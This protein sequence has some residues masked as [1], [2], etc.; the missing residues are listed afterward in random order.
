MLI[1][2]VS[3]EDRRFKLE[4]GAGSD[5]VH[6]NPVYSFAVTRLTLD[7]GVT[8]TGLVLTM[9]RG[10]ELVCSA[11]DLLGLQL[12]GKEIEELMSNFGRTFRQLADDAQLR[13]LGPHKGVVHLALASITNACFDAWAK[14]RQLPLWKLL[15]SLSPT[16]ILALLD[17]SYLEEVLD[18]PSAEKILTTHLPSR[19]EREGVILAGYPGYDTSVG[20]YQYSSTQIEERVRRSVDAGFGAF[21]LKVGG[22]LGQDLSRATGL[23]R[24]A[25]DKATIMFDANQQWNYPQ[26]LIACKE[27][28]I[29]DPLWIEEPTHPDDVFAHKSLA[30]AIAPT[31]LALG[32][33]VP[34]RV[35]FKN[36]LQA[37]CVK[38]LQPDCTRLGGVSEFL[39]VSL[40][41]RKF[42]VPVVPHVGDMGQIHQHLVI[43]NH[44]A[45]GHPDI[46]LE[47]IPHLSA[48]FVNP[49][50]IKDG[51]Y[52][53]P[54]KA[55]CSTDLI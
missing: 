35:I 25:G 40:M 15:L 44:V 49:A 27:L 48:H 16:E 34:N 53:T 36:F 8:G 43:F 29:L 38:F 1:K 2:S 42:G 7:T 11:I 18:S 4:A 46:F 51:R 21:K 47:Y 23:R 26:A 41:A 55:G 31:A 24:V 9:G 5:A 6:S 13:W 22:S 19:P 17:L 45:L 37:G 10:N 12:E 50:V 14:A 33:H 52:Q 3:T 20:W 28:A 54:Q 30:D 39:T 32:E